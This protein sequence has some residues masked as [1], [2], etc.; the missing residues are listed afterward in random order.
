ME[1]VDILDMT[2]QYL[3]GKKVDNRNGRQLMFLVVFLI[4]QACVSGELPYV[5]L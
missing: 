5:N 3:K 4:R 1:K 2:V